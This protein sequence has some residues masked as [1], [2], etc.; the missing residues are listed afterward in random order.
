ML[1]S[2]TII[3]CAD[4]RMREAPI[5]ATLDKTPLADISVTGR[6][7]NAHL[8]SGHDRTYTII[9]MANLPALTLNIGFNIV[10]GFVRSLPSV[11]LLF[12]HLVLK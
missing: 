8:V 9:T 6:A 7:G 3:T 1:G 4:C 5:E 11:L 2:L 12:Y 10:H